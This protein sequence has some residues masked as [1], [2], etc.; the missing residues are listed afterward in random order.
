MILI[1]ETFLVN[2]LTRKTT[3]HGVVDLQS[4]SNN[5][6]IQLDLPLEQFVLN[7]SEKVYVEITTTSPS[8]HEWDLEMKEGIVYEM[9]FDKN[10]LQCSFSGLLCSISSSNSI[11]KELKMGSN[12]SLFLALVVPKQN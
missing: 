12:L 6:R 4:L 9:D 1:A 10:T 7:E 2:K 3:L 8:N 11:P 5:T